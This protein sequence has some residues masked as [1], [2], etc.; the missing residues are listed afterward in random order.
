MKCEVSKGVNIHLLGIWDHN[1]SQLLRPPRVVSLPSDG[2]AG[3]KL[4]TMRLVS[5]EDMDA[6]LWP[7][8]SL[9]L[10][11]AHRIRKRSELETTLI[12]RGT[13]GFLGVCNV[14]L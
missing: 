3:F 2:S 10:M 12:S 11:V 4:L 14:L 13:V 9:L 6:I 8:L 1:Y 5:P 7:Y